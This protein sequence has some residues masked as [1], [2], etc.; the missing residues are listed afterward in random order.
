MVN[1]IQQDTKHIRIKIQASNN[2]EEGGVYDICWGLCAGTRHH[3]WVCDHVRYR[4]HHGV[5]E[6]EWEGAR[7]RQ[8]LMVTMNMINKME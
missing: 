3:G 7:E 8:V 2:P 1:K 4:E 6:W 5:W